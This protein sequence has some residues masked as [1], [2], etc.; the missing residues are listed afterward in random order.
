MKGMIARPLTFCDDECRLV[1]I[2]AVV[3]VLLSL[4]EN[5]DFTQ[6]FALLVKIDNLT[7]YTSMVE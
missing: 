7:S 1:F 4:I 6:F 5:V 3:S 2:N